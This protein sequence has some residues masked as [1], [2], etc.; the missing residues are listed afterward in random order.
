[1]GKT[2]KLVACFVL[3]ALVVNHEVQASCIDNCL[4]LCR[5]IAN[6]GLICLP[7]CFGLNC[8]RFPSANAQMTSEGDHV[9]GELPPKIKAELIEI[10]NELKQTPPGSKTITGDK[11]KDT[12]NGKRIATIGPKLMNNIN[13]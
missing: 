2:F 10:G 6:P 4:E 7:E 12:A 13:L 11:S 5:A 9:K 3:V 1:M 8:L